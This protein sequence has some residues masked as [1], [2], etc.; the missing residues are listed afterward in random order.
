MQVKADG[1]PAEGVPFVY[2]GRGKSPFRPAQAGEKGFDGEIELNINLKL[3][4]D[5]TGI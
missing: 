1:T 3:R 2:Q 4:P 5:K